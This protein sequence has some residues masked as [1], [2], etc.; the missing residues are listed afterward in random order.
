MISFEPLD[1]HLA[2]TGETKSSLKKY[3]KH[4]FTIDTVKDIERICL[5]L[6]VDIERVME[7]IDDRL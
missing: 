7:Y 3:K 4:A 2:L 5:K 6:N 1:R